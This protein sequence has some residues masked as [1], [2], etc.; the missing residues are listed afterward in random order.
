MSEYI[1]VMAI[2][3]AVLIAMNPMI[4]RG[5]QGFIKVV[6]D[7]IGVQNESDQRFN[8]ERAGHLQRSYSATRVKSDKVTIDTFGVVNYY[9]PGDEI[10]GDADQYSNLGYS[11]QGG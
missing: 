7:Q 9:Y 8:S 4:K 11:E 10:Q 2:V 1:V 6:A 5:T 3:I